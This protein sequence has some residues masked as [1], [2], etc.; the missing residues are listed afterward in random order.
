MPGD[1]ARLLPGKAIKKFT[2]EVAEN[3]E[4]IRSKI[5]NLVK[6]I[7]GVIFSVFSALSVVKKV[8]A[9]GEVPK[10]S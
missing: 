3:A 5:I 8:F 10:W 9:T 2:A 6:K 7:Q 4:I 1:L